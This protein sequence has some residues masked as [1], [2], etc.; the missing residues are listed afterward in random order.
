AAPRLRSRA[1]YFAI[2]RRRAPAST[3]PNRHGRPSGAGCELG[4][5]LG[6][7]LINFTGRHGT[8]EVEALQ[9][10]AARGHDR[11]GVVE[12]LDAFRNRAHLHLLSKPGNRMNDR[13]AI[14]AFREIEIANETAVDLDFIEGEAA[15]VTER[16]VRRAEVI[17]GDA[18]T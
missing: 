5:A 14:V 11:L 18:D 17:K 4:A 13:Q 8:A 2:Q 7:D 12:C 9:L 6:E 15:Q 3:P 1:R 16:G 10:V